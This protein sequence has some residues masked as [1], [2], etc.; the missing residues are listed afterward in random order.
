VKDLPSDHL[1]III[2]IKAFIDPNANKH[3]IVTNFNKAQ[4]DDFTKYAEEHFEQHNNNTITNIETTTKLF[5]NI[6]M[7]DIDKIYIPKGI[8]KKINPNYTP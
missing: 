7:N 5:N 2:T 8:I 4:W 6:I 1:P 3:K